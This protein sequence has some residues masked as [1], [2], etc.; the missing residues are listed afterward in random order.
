MEPRENL[1]HQWPYLLSFLPAEEHLEKTAR[2]WGA[3]RRKRAV[4][5]AATLL[6]LA[7]VYGFCGFSLRQTAAWAEASQVASL[8]DVAL[9]KRFRK[10]ADWLGHLL[11]SKLAERVMPVP[12][13]QTRVR[14]IDA[15]TVSAPGS[16]GT[17]WRLHLDFD[18]GALAISEVQ[19][20]QVSGGESL[21][22]YEFEPGELVIADRGYAHRSGLAHVVEGQAHFIVRLNWSA[23]PLQQPGGAAFDLLE[24]VRSLPE[25][26]AG[27]FDVEIQLKSEEQIP[28]VPVRLIV[29]RKSEE[30][31]QRAREKVLKEATKKGRK[32][33]PQTLELA[34]Y[35]LLLTSTSAEDFS[36]EDVL[37]IYR[38]RWQVELVFKKLKGVLQLGELPAKDPQLARTFLF[39]KLLA[40]LLLE[41]LTMDYLSFSPWGFRLRLSTSALPVADPESSSL[42]PALRSSRP[43][44]ARHLD[45]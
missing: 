7:L 38:F 25:A 33:R 1:E 21:L 37:E 6:R 14:L 30:A 5:S 35:V 12:A 40:S 32:V 11:G 41:E 10:A 18:L 24:A 20:S 22:R 27:S 8:S 13:N 15:T 17:D 44:T 36:P 43:H 31:A 26:Q 29:L 4:D 34:S 42:Q 2:S 45:A 19:L 16:Q 23:V 39:S 3:I 28:A 9:L